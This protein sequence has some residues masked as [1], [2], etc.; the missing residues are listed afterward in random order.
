MAFE[1]LM[2]D[3]LAMNNMM[4]SM[5]MTMDCQ[6]GEIVAHMKVLEDVFVTTTWAA[7]LLNDWKL[8]GH[9]S[10]RMRRCRR[11][12]RP[13]VQ[14]SATLHAFGPVMRAPGRMRTI[15]LRPIMK[16]MIKNRNLRLHHLH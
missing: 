13:K 8:R 1:T 4:M 15:K 2:V 16:K 12:K 11:T 6:Q 14:D 3:S 10:R 5:L 9:Q 7:C